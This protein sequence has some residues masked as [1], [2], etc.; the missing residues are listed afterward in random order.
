MTR[1]A[2]AAVAA[3]LAHASIAESAKSIGIAERTLRRW[4]AREDFRRKYL[5]ARR[6]A[7]DR[8][9]DALHRHALEAVTTLRDVM[10]DAAAPASARVSAARTVLE[11]GRVSI[12][13]DDLCERL[14]SV[15]RVLCV[16]STA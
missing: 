2:E 5:A 3:L 14:E 4:L 11:L 8:A 16:R 15:E 7:F 12:E 13:L 10:L 6:S 9:I 1:K